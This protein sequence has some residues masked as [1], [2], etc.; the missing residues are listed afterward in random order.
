[1][2]LVSGDRVWR[3]LQA[4]LCVPYPRLPLASRGLSIVF[5]LVAFMSFFFL[6]ST[7]PC[8]YSHLRSTIVQLARPPSNIKHTNTVRSL[9]S[10][11]KDSIRLVYHADDK[12][13]NAESNPAGTS[14]AHIEF[15]FDCDVP[16]S[17]T[18]HFAVSESTDVHG[19]T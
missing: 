17:V 18:V 14:N 2:R 5:A 19:V 6:T 15:T 12:N 13:E 3:S 9:L 16:C 10:L 11:H 4:Q 1:M 7:K 8:G